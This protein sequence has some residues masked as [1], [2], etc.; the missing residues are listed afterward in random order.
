VTIYE[1]MHDAAQKWAMGNIRLR[2]EECLL[3]GGG[4]LEDVVFKK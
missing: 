3:K 2:L 1:Y 4:Y